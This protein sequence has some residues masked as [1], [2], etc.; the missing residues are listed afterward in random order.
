MVILWRK[1]IILKIGVPRLRGF[2]AGSSRWGL[3]QRLALLVCEIKNRG[4]PIKIRGLS[5]P[6]KGFFKGLGVVKGEGVATAK[7]AS[8]FP[9][10]KEKFKFL[11]Y[12]KNFKSAKIKINSKFKFSKK[13][14]I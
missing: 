4:T 5:H 3:S 14:K 7:K 2:S 10:K 13:Y 9:L 1:F 6:L 12:F 8:P 11:S